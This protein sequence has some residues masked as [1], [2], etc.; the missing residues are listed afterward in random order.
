MASPADR[1][2]YTKD[3]LIALKPTNVANV[4]NVTTATLT[5]LADIPED[6]RRRTRAATN[7]YF[8]K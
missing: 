1:I 7:Y 5:R 4:T 2:V 3:Q 6:C 8:D